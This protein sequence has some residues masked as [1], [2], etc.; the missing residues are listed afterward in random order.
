MILLSTGPAAPDSAYEQLA[1][2][3]AEE[4]ITRM[5]AAG[6]TISGGGDPS[7]SLADLLDLG[8]MK[9][10]AWAM[11]YLEKL[12]PEQ[13]SRVYAH[14]IDRLAGATV[15]QSDAVALA[16][17][18]AS[19]LYEI[20]PDM[21]LER[22]SAAEDDSLLQQALLLGLFETKS[23]AVGQAAAALRRI[24][25]GR[26]DSLAL[27]LMAKHSQ[28]LTPQDI[29]QLGTIA[30]GGGRVSEILQVQAAWLY[31]KH[32]GQIETALA[33]VFADSQTSKSPNVQN[34]K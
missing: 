1:S 13:A 23:P 11:D 18:A 8:H 19:K 29:E 30:A 12:P 24:G 6:K 14:L 3:G 26:A 2:V 5:I 15:P 17:Q 21:V 31:F 22:L 34:S 28:P 32:T 25:S 27:L 9:T 7:D 10:T 20:K 16:V 4:L 33:A